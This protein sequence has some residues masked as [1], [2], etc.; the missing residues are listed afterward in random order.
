MAKSREHTLIAKMS[1][2]AVF[3][4]LSFVMT[5]FL[6]IPYAGNAGYFNF[7]DIVT[8]LA[9]MVLGPIEGALIGI[10]GG[11]LSDLFLGYAFY[12]P[13]TI[14][15]K[16]LMGLATG[17]LYSVLKN[18]KGLRF[19]ARMEYS[20]VALSYICSAFIFPFFYLV[21]IWSYITG[22][23]ILLRPEVEFIIIRSI[24]FDGILILFF[25]HFS[26]LYRQPR[27]AESDKQSE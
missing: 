19:I 5:A 25:F 17:F 16:G 8:L 27:S 2:V 18:K 3:G 1:A 20:T 10:V 4:A 23:T 7:G 22:K 26:V 13:W 14:L 6:K 9:S 11:A 24:Y 12:A 21:P 15:A